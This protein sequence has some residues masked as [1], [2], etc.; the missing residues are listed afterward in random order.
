[1]SASDASL[2]LTCSGACCCWA[3]LMCEPPVEDEVLAAL[4]EGAHHGFLSQSKKCKPAPDVVAVGQCLALDAVVAVFEQCRDHKPDDVLCHRQQR[5]A[6]E[7]GAEGVA[8]T[9]A[10]PHLHDAP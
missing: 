2:R 9:N 7:R 10:R 6:P 8:G 5:A 3:A 1:M 4:A